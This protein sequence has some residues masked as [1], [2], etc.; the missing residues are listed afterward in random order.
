MSAGPTR[1]PRRN[2]TSLRSS[3]NG[4]SRDAPEATE[5]LVMVSSR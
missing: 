3:V 1:C 2:P 4:W 5:A